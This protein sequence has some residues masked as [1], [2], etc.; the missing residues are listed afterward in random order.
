[1]VRANLHVNTNDGFGQVTRGIKAVVT[2]VNAKLVFTLGAKTA[3]AFVTGGVLGPL[4]LLTHV[5]FGIN[6]RRNHNS[7]PEENGQM[8]CH[9]KALVDIEDTALSRRAPRNAA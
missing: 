3:L 6:F 2:E 4:K 5:N 9:K 7:S 8:V 1:V